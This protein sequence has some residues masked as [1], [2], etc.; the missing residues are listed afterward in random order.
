MIGKFSSVDSV[1]FANPVSLMYC[2]NEN[3]SIV[4][5]LFGVVEIVGLRINR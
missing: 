1:L 5:R 3:V 2:N 4:Q